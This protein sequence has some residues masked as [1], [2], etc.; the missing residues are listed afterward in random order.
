MI[1]DAPEPAN[2]HAVGNVGAML[3]T[4]LMAFLLRKGVLKPQDVQGI[5]QETHARY[6][7]IPAGPIPTTEWERQTSALLALL[8]QDV[9]KFGS[10]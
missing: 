7:S 2:P 9:L 1:T 8:Q 3:A 5:F 10:E 4:H 6:T